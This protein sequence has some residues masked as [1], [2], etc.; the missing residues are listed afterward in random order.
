MKQGFTL[1]ELLIVVAIIAILAAIAVP[2]FLEAQVRSKVARVKSDMRTISLGMAAYQVDNNKP[3]L[4]YWDWYYAGKAGQS[5]MRGYCY[6]QLTTPIA[7]LSSIPEDPFMS[8]LPADVFNRKDLQIFTYNEFLG[9]KLPAMVAY[10]KARERC[11]VRGFQYAIQSVGPSRVDNNPVINQMLGGP[12]GSGTSFDSAIGGIYDPTNGT[13]S[14]GRIIRT[15][16][17]PGTGG[18]ISYSTN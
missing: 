4:D 2:N 5:V 14:K 11:W 10:D 15:N 9:A 1:I 3:P 18:D 7:Y 13:A 8:S 12:P 16:K 6:A 17:G